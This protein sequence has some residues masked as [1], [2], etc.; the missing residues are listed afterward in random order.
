MNRPK[1]TPGHEL[2]HVHFFGI[3]SGEGDRGDLPA[4]ADVGGKAINLCRLTRAKF[5]VPPGF[6]VTT[7]GYL[8]FI[9]E[10]GLG[11]QIAGLSASIGDGDAAVIDA[12]S[13]QI[14]ALLAGHAMPKSLAGE[15]LEAYH[16]LLDAGVERVAVRSSAT[17]EDLPEASFAGQQDTYLNVRGEA[18]LLKAVQSCW[19][20]LWTT[21]A[22]AYRAKQKTP[23]EGL[24]MAVVVQKMVMADAAGVLF[25]ANPL[26]GAR[27]EIIVNAAWGL[28]EAIV[29][30]EVTPDRVVVDKASGRIKE[31]TVSEKATM[32]VVTEDGTEQVALNEDR[33]LARVLG[34]NEVLRLAAIG[35]Q[36][37]LHYGT[38]QDIEW[39]MA[40]GQFAVLQARPIRGLEV[41][42]DVEAGRIAE[43][44]RLGALS[45]SRRR[46]WV[47]HNLGETLTAPTPLT[48]DIIRQFMSGQGGFG[49]FYHDLGYRP[50]SQVCEEGFLELIGQRIYADPER[51]AQMFWGNSPLQ[52]DLEAMLADN[53]LLDRAPIQFDP[54]KADGTFLLKLPAML[55]TMF[56]SWRISKRLRATIREHFDSEV[57]PP[58]LDYVSRKRGEDLGGLE[59]PQ[60]CAE[61]RA[62]LARVLDEFGKESL[63]PGFF[64]ALAF[65]DLRHMLVQLLGEAEG[66]RL[67][68]ALTA[69]LEGDTTVA[70]NQL[71]Y[72]VARGEVAMQQFLDAYGH[73]TAGEMELAEPRYREAPHQLDSTLQALR[74][75]DRS[76]EEIHQEHA[77][78]RAEVERELPALLA[79]WGGSSFRER[80][81]TSIRQ[82]QQLLAYRESGKHYLML[83]YELI[84]AAVLELARRWRLGR[85]V[86][87]LRLEELEHFEARRDEFLAAAAHRQVRWQS[88]QRLDMPAVIDSAELPQLGL[89]R[90][91]ASA[92]ELKGEAVAAGVAT[93][94]ARI[95]FDPRVPHD[96]GENY[97]LVCPSTDPGWTPLFVNARGLVMERGGVLSHGAIVA[98]DFGIPAVV[99]AGAMKR[100][101]DGSQLHL[102]GNRGMIHLLEST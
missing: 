45:G 1:P 60:V 58:Y 71:L 8:G 67:A 38:P 81:T 27:D 33:R 21:R 80:I 28:G 47:A 48:W 25:T 30:G 90:Q 36:I 75:S 73:R 62:R 4:L 83:G 46:I 101:K 74:R 79:P 56:R 99:C 88:L 16:R 41:A 91:Y 54:N 97:I 42:G 96:L 5:P 100:I 102:D 14:R 70:Q 55:A 57:L 50:S 10:D 23:A 32:T 78:R 65:T 68:S 17:A 11:R 31:L 51:L 82:T 94:T 89:P 29:G 35:R 64:G 87:F 49:R 18:P 12:V 76:P 20:S 13:T 84:R 66:G 93:G 44:E 85:D 72:R 59:T 61:L 52:Y 34:D 40:A 98:R 37:E 53:S 22:V 95:V 86:F 92:A 43:I 77:R 39:A 19:G 69:G 9:G 2:P 7:R 26:T 3:D 24:A 15:I 6:V 63:K